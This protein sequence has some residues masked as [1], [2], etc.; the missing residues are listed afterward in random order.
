MVN[1]STTADKLLVANPKGEIYTCEGTQNEDLDDSESSGRPGNIEAL[2]TLHHNSD[3]GPKSYCED[4]Q[5]GM[6]LR[7]TMICK[8]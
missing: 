1:K 4:Y 8:W 5:C 3:E 6:F 7:M 2:P